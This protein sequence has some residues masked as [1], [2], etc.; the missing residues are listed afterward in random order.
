MKKMSIAKLAALMAVMATAGAHA[1][2]NSVNSQSADV[3]FTDSAEIVH[4]LEKNGP[5]PSGTADSLA[6]PV[7]AVGKVSS[8]TPT[9]H[10]AIQWGNNGVNSCL[11]GGAQPTTLC[12]LNNTAGVNPVTFKLLQAGDVELPN[13]G[14]TADGWFGKTT[15]LL[16]YNV[17]LD[18][19]VLAEGVYT[20]Q[21]SAAAYTS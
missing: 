16:N 20:L 12:Q 11:G 5:F 2:V 21:V 10:I 15:G 7:V 13:A 9:T 18:S 14:A 17:R 1:A 6:H 3:T 8:K 19:G 4:T